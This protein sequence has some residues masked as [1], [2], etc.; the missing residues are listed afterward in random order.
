MIIFGFRKEENDVIRTKGLIIEDEK[1]KPRIVM[2]HPIPKL[3][4]RLRKDTIYGIALLSDKGIDRL[5]ISDDARRF[6]ANG[7]INTRTGEIKSAAGFFINDIS[8]NERSGWAFNEGKGINMGFDYPSEEAVSMGVDDRSKGTYF[9]MNAPTRGREKIVLY[10]SNQISW[11]KLKNSNSSDIMRLQAV[12]SLPIKIVKANST[13]EDK[14]VV[15][16][17]KPSKD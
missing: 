1:G 14:E 11:L 9:V 2:G 7:K 5:F 12:D 13:G 4:S 17:L 3:D 16:K 6:Q 10:A 15:L 8:G